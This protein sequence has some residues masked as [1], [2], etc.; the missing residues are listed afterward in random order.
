MKQH[1]ARR[2]AAIEG[3][4]GHRRWYALEDRH[5]ALF[6]GRLVAFAALAAFV[7]LLPDASSTEQSLALLIGAGAIVMHSVLRWVPERWPGRLRFAVD[8]SLLVDA[9]AV[10]SL[11]LVSGGSD[12][13]VLWALL[14]LAVAVTLGY[15]APT[16]LKAVILAAMAALGLQALD[17]AQTVLTAE[18]GRDLTLLVSLVAAAAFFSSVNE[19]ELRR[20][21]DR[22]TTLHEAT[23]AFVGVDDPDELGAVGRRAASELLPGWAVE[24]DL[25]EPRA[26]GAEDSERTWRAD[27][28][29][30]L[31]LPVVAVVAGE[32]ADHLVGQVLAHRAAPRVGP[33]RLRG[34]QMLA[35]RTL[36]TTM[37]GAVLQA[38][39]LRRLEELSVADELTGIGNR[40]AFDSTLAV[41][42]GRAARTRLPLSLVLLDVDHFKRFNDE[43]GHQAGDQAL[44]RV[45]GVLRDSL[46]AADSAC[47]FGGEEFA[48][49]LPATSEREAMEVAERLRQEIAASPTAHGSVTVSMGVAETRG[50]L[51][52]AG[53]IG[54][55]DARLYHAKREGR[56]RVVGPEGAAPRAGE[57][58][59]RIPSPY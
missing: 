10:F 11:A 49:L 33:E 14:I 38:D 53:L 21:S 40:R 41:E 31:A 59:G 24:V 17:G 23:A 20:R 46:R 32:R 12:S 52:A 22:L 51:P 2:G 29:V 19:R 45:A 7:A 4:R 43:H 8:T 6:H 55:A 16:G 47:R 18:N 37:A 35:L 5:E 1:T 48:V 30:Y 56:D 50:G 58:P 34:Q 39:L 25:H 44:Q 42:V 13:P 57:P 15:S 26:S 9:G 3:V 28:R 54:R 36:V 27:G